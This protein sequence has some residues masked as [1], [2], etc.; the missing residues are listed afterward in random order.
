MTISEA[1]L[2]TIPLVWLP[3]EIFVSKDMSAFKF[4]LRWTLLLAGC[5]MLS[6]FMHQKLAK[7]MGGEWTW[8]DAI[9]YGWLLFSFFA[10]LQIVKKQLGRALGKLIRWPA[11]EKMRKAFVLCTYYLLLFITMI[12]FFLAMTTVHRV[13]I[14]DAFT[15]ETALGVEY[16]DVGLKTQDGLT[17]KAWFVPA[18]SGQAVIIA[19]GLGANKSNF[20]GTVDMWHQLGF[21]VLIFDF[22]GHGMSAGHTVTFGYRE[23]LDVLAGLKYLTEKEGFTPD[24]IVGYG[25]SFGGAAMIH[26]ASEM[27]HFHKIIIDSSFASLDDMADT[28]INSEPIIPV[29]FRKLF[30]ELGLFF[31]RLDTG[32]D[33]REHSPER[34]V[35]QLAGTPLLFI[36]GKGDPLINWKQTERL[37][38]RAESPKKS[39]FLET[40]GH[41]GTMSDPGYVAM[42]GA[43]VAD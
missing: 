30:K 42:I 16:K 34:V 36:H 28:I 13:K 5:L 11:N 19:H 3:W 7:M 18:N 38:A 21:N 39:V 35:G 1:V 41:F 25:V 24:R 37:F 12:P 23:R 4:L 26:A 10:I 29:F 8:G 2:L 20:I 15:P 33:I 6:F 32:V 31:V 22:R 9:Y 27:K 17:L 14:A 43:F 40:D